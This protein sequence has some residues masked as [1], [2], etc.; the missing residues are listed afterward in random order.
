LELPVFED[1]LLHETTSTENTNAAKRK[2][3]FIKPSGNK[4]QIVNELIV[5]FAML[6]RSR[7]LRFVQAETK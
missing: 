4:F 5:R 3:F 2:S 1:E 6:S 7:R